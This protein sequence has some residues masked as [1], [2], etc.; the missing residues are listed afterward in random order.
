MSTADASILPEGKTLQIPLDEGVVRELTAGEVVYL[1]GTVFTGRSLVHLRAV[2][3]DILPPV[4]G[5]S[6]VLMHV[7]P[8]MRRSAG[9]DWEVMS[10]TPTSSLRFERYGADIVK[11]MRLRAV[12][13]KTTMGER[14]MQMMSKCGC[15]H[16]TSVGVCGNTLA[17]TVTQ[18]T[19]VYFRDELGNTEATW[20]MEVDRAGPF[21]VDIDTRGG[22]LFRSLHDRV[23]HRLEVSRKRLGISDDFQFTLQGPPQGRGGT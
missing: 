4:A 21:I 14:T 10:M 11:L 8:V 16:L 23:S 20:V 22:N 18:V 7:G 19:D 1:S 15:V 6:N 17:R 13:G 3:E 12:I 2:E 9:G 5:V